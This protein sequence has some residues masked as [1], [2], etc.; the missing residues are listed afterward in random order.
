MM[1]VGITSSTGETLR[2]RDVSCLKEGEMLNDR[3]LQHFLQKKF[4]EELCDKDQENMHLFDTLFV[5]KI[6][7]TDSEV[8][9]P[10]RLQRK[11]K[12][13]LFF[14]V[15]SENHFSLMVYF[16]QSV[17]VTKT[18]VWTR[19]QQIGYFLHM[20][21]HVG[22]HDTET[23]AKR[24]GK[25][26][27]KYYR[28]LQIHDVQFQ[29]NTII[30][31]IPQQT[32]NFDCGCYVLTYFEKLVRHCK[33]YSWSRKS[34]VIPYDDIKYRPTTLDFYK[35]IDDVGLIEINLLRV[36][37]ALDL[38]KSNQELFSYKIHLCE[39]SIIE[40]ENQLEKVKHPYSTP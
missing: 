11:D 38:W 20:D 18:A 28:D 25:F 32:N 40:I 39:Q 3:V 23:I 19:R 10:S 34:C 21:P 35:R 36:R 14:P 16:R 17:A 15:F 33:N 4:N 31:D 8:T 9:S 1:C 13:V 6:L 27:D 5:E 24:L 37:L 26:V 22:Y 7:N 30:L 12:S 29:I 2:S